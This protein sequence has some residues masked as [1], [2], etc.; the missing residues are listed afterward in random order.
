MVHPVRYG[1]AAGGAFVPSLAVQVVRSLF[2]EAL[3]DAAEAAEAA[4]QGAGGRAG[5]GLTAAAATGAVRRALQTVSLDRDWER[6]GH[7]IGSG[8]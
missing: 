7:Q 4:M 1:D 2:A 8:F 5:A 6:C 3:E